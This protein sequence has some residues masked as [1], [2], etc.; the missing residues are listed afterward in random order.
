M[1][2]CEGVEDGRLTKDTWHL[3]ENGKAH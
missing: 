3:R 1:G 2:K